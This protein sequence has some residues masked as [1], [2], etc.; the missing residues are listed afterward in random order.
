MG[1][2]KE[3]SG[4][5]I[6]LLILEFFKTGLFSVGG[7]L[8]TL[9]FLY[10]M[11]EKYGWFSGEDVANMLAVSESTPGPIGVNMATFTGVTV[12]GVLGG[13]IAT[14][15]LVTP[16]FLIILI[17]AK[18]LQ[19]FR[20]NRFVQ[21]SLSMLRPVSVG[22]IAAAV[23][24]VF[25]A[26]LISKNALFAGDWGSITSW[27]AVATFAVLLCIYLKWKKLHPVVL[28]AIGAVAGIVL[29]L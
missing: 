5:T 11:S 28:V 29:Q 27:G 6:L 14:L 2:G 1:E 13:V 4:M 25:T 19:R 22:L 26:S 9:P 10:Q 12:S 8:A 23:I 18:A 21:S 16:S 7:G 24:S 17:I 3:E 20:E 15:A